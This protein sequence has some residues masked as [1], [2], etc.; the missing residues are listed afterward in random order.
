VNAPKVKRLFELYAYQSHTLV[1]LADAL[2]R[3]GIIYRDHTPRFPKA[4]LFTL[5]TNRHCI[6]EARLKGMWYPGNFEAIIDLATFQAVQDKFG[7]RVYRKPQITFASCLIRCDHCGYVM[8]GE[9][10][11]KKLPESTVKEYTYYKCSQ[12]SQPGH[13]DSR[14]AEREIDEQVLAFFGRLEVKDPNVRQRIVEVIRAKAHTA[15]TQN[16]Q[17]RDELARQKKQVEEKLRVLLDLRVEGEISSDEYAAKRRELNGRQTAIRLQLEVADRDDREIAEQAIKAF[18]LSQTL[19]T[20]WKTA[21]PA[22]K[23]TILD[24]LCESIRELAESALFGPKTLQSA[25]K[26]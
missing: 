26:R 15:N 1:T 14:L 16:R 18:E 19:K 9:R 20:R 22:S 6:G 12:S 17:H 3:Q 25:R 11:R 13:P 4:S 5:L 8:T 10:I 23:R 7:G 21:D 2:A 24:I